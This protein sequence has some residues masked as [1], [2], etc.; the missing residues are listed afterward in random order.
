MSISKCY[1]SHDICCSQMWCVQGTA[2]PCLD[3]LIHR[4]LLIRLTRNGKVWRAREESTDLGVWQHQFWQRAFFL[5]CKM[6]PILNVLTKPRI[7]STSHSLILISLISK[8]FDTKINASTTLQALREL[9]AKE[10][11]HT[12]GKKESKFCQKTKLSSS[13]LEKMASSSCQN[14]SFIS[15][16]PC[17]TQY[18]MVYFFLS[19]LFLQ[20]CTFKFFHLSFSP[21]W[22]FLLLLMVVVV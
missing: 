21:W 4:H 2:Q 11:R 10:I 15:N 13:W 1:V 14:F 12:H 18:N 7:W 16:F 3:Y 8:A 5:F 17:N 6:R 20:S 9:P 22:Y 19:A